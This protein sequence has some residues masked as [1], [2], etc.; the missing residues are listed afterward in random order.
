MPDEQCERVIKKNRSLP[1]Q[2][3]KQRAD[4]C[5]HRALGVIYKGHTP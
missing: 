1:P 2:L 4:A 5:V 3:S